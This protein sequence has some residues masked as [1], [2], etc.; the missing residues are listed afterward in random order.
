M[1]DLQDE[2]P[3]IP[4]PRSGT[5]TDQLNSLSGSE[6]TRWNGFLE[7]YGR[8]GILLQE[9]IMLVSTL[10]YPIAEFGRSPHWSSNG[11]H[12]LAKPPKVGEH[13][14]TLLKEAS[15]PEC[16][17]AIEKR[18]IT[19]NIITVEHLSPPEPEGFQDWVTDGR[20]WCA[21][22]TA[23]HYSESD[24]TVI[25]QDLLTLYSWFPDRD[26]NLM[27]ERYRVMLS[28]HAHLALRYIFRKLRKKRVILNDM[29]M[30]YNLALQVIGHR[31]KMLYD[32]TRKVVD[33]QRWDLYEDDQI[34]EFV[35][36]Y[37]L[38]DPPKL[39]GTPHIH[40]LSSHRIALQTLRTTSFHHKLLVPS[41]EETVAF[42][43]QVVV[44]RHTIDLK[45]WGM[46][47]YALSDL[48]DIAEIDQS[49]TSREQI[50]KLARAWRDTALVSR[51]PLEMTALCAVL[52]RLREFATLDEIPQENHLCCGCCL[53]RAG[54]LQ[55]A[56]RF[57]SSGIHYC[58]QYV[59]KAPIWRYHFELWTVR[60]RLGQWIEAERWLSITWE[61][62]LTRRNPLPAGAVDLWKQSGELG[63]FRMGLASLLSD[64][65]I[66]Q[67]RFVEARIT[68]LI[69]LGNTLPMRNV[70]ITETRVA[71][72]SRLLGVLLQLQDLRSAAEMASD[73]CREL[74]LQEATPG[75]LTR[76]DWTA[77]EVLA[78]VDQ[79]VHERLYETAC[80]L[81]RELKKIPF[82]AD[83]MDDYWNKVRAKENFKDSV[84]QSEPTL[85]LTLPLENPAPSFQLSHNIQSQMAGFRPIIRE[86]EHDTKDS[87]YTFP[88]PTT[89]FE[90]DPIPAPMIAENEYQE[91]QAISN[92]QSE[93]GKSRD[94]VFQ[95]PQLTRWKKALSLSWHGRLDSVFLKLGKLPRPPANEPL[96]FELGATDVSRRPSTS[97]I[98]ETE[99]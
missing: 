21:R 32:S 40:D 89:M 88:S 62:L 13:F 66:A 41:L 87:G 90:T 74:Q 7:I 38:P 23:Q 17:Q 97:R 55:L 43:D 37:L 54:Y 84:S 83:S 99:S 36:G 49:E 1:V 29:E 47:G 31:R 6:L 30:F 59:P 63:E 73:L 15:G 60:M 75:W 10:Y 3:T 80:Y 18:L 50:E 12:D 34:L 52:V 35:H 65:Y 48:M 71:L 91:P 33:K 96:S 2:Y 4:E 64:C 51:T 67:D 56:V 58:E 42:F 11:Q 20:S 92:T 72:M 27:A 94:K 44:Q 82:E 14:L 8:Q 98:S 9:L 61:K 79:L 81:L 22:S 85:D 19:L 26:V 68:L 86:S 46:V 24:E 93:R 69:A 53:S 95:R 77:R 28:N 78:C 57:I 70:A 16:L 45:A 39:R 76:V 25:C 5:F